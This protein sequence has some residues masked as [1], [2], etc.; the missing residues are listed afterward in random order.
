MD[1]SQFPVIS[2]VVSREL[3]INSQKV[4][5]ERKYPEAVSQSF[6]DHRKHKEGENRKSHLDD[7]EDGEGDHHRSLEEDSHDKYD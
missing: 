1:A 5:N 3:T 6:E 4:P 7:D 2:P